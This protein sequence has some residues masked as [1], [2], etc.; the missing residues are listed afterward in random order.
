MVISVGIDPSFESR[1]KRR[2]PEQVIILHGNS[3][4]LKRRKRVKFQW[5]MYRVAT[6]LK[7]ALLTEQMHE[8][9]SLCTKSRVDY[10]FFKL[11]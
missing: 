6:A 7:F 4:V 10:H 1:S 3:T 2:R 8:T 11:N 5:K 9:L